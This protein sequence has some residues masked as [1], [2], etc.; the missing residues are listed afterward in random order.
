MEDKPKMHIGIL[1]AMPEEIG[2]F[3]SN[4][5]SIVK[6]NMVILLSFLGFGKFRLQ[7]KFSFQFVLVGG[8]KLVLLE[9]LLD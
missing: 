6:K 2:T 7:K 1:G 5:D 3:L 8:A 4:L 9:L